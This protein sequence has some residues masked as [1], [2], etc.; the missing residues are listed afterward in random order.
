MLSKLICALIDFF[1]N[2]H[3]LFHY[4]L[5]SSDT[6]IG[7][8]KEWNAMD[9]LTCLEIDWPTLHL[10]CDLVPFLNLKLEFLLFKV[11]NSFCWYL[12]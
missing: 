8:E 6:A 12:L 10:P 5:G 9:E 11:V 7:N 1:E 2:L 3:F 4:S